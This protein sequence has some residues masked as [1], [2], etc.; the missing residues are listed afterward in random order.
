[1]ARQMCGKNWIGDDSSEAE[2][3]FRQTLL[4]LTANGA[5]NREISESVMKSPFILG[6]VWVVTAKR[7]IKVPNQDQ[8]ASKE[9][10]PNAGRRGHP[11]L[12]GPWEECL[13]RDPELRDE[14]RSETVLLI[15]KSCERNGV[16][17][18]DLTRPKIGGYWRVI[19]IYKAIK[20]AWKL[21][22]KSRYWLRQSTSLDEKGTTQPDGDM[23]RLPDKKAKPH[24][25]DLRLDLEMAIAE[26]ECPRQREVLRLWLQD[27]GYREIA[28]QL[29][30][31]YDQVRF[32]FDKARLVLRKQL[33]GAA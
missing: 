17:G 33:P 30:L 10:G 5:S 32:A 16:L 8:S 7:S 13:A 2:E 27:Y 23:Q 22:V 15:A 9:R 14:W 12:P 3:K 29:G 6:L 26:L 19:V 28:D 1:M 20:A 18:C 21:W 24:A 11:R 25:T 31:T 4:R